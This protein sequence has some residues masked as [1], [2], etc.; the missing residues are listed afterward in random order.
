MATFTAWKTPGTISSQT[1][2]GGSQSWSN[3]SNAG[4]SD[5][6]YATTASLSSTSTHWLWCTNFDFSSIPSGATI[7]GVKVRYERKQSNN[8]DGGITEA[9]LQ[10]IKGGSRTG[11]E[12][13]ITEV[14]GW[15]TSDGVSAD[16][17]GT[18]DVWSATF[19]RTEAIAS[20]T[21]V[22]F[23]C[24][25]TGGIGTIPSIDVVEMAFEYTTSNPRASS[26][27]LLFNALWESVVSTCGILIAQCIYVKNLISEPGF[28]L[29]TGRS[30]GLQ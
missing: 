24:G 7:T 20:D 11:T 8:T 13:H 16:A 19:T 4:T 12:K 15:A 18:G 9:Y 6:S 14:S 28:Q 17:G 26:F 27:F 30:L 23:A 25:D 22:A 1:R 29:T 2:T 21:G 10:L 3:P 5:N